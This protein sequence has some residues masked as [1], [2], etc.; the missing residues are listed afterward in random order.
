MDYQPK[1][2]IAMR[3]RVDTY[4]LQAK[5]K[6][7]QSAADTF[8]QAGDDILN[9]ALSLPSY[10]GQLS[11]PAGA[12]QHDG[13]LRHVHPAGR[14]SADRADVGSGPAAGGAGEALQR[15]GGGLRRVR[16]PAE[17]GHVDKQQGVGA[18]I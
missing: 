4:D 2:G 7:Y 5:A 9:I 16:Q 15:R 12:R 18:A 8:G 1:V 10:D 13:V 11:G 3:I 14:R 17:R 6:N